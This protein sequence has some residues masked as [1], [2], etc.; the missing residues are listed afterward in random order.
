MPRNCCFKKNSNKNNTCSKKFE[1]H[2]QN[3]KKLH[4]QK[5]A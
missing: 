3:T 2:V 4:V 1:M 5:K